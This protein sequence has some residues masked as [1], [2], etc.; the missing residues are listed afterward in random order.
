MPNL[1]P[2]D[3]MELARHVKSLGNELKSRGNHG[4]AGRPGHRGGSAGRGG[5]GGAS[6]PAMTSPETHIVSLA[7]AEAHR[8]EKEANKRLVLQRWL[9]R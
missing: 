8:K 3:L 5:S 2:A 7:D 4:H 9:N 1:N 6:Q